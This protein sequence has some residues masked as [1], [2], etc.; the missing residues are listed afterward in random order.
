MKSLG[1]ALL[2]SLMVVSAGCDSEPASISAETQVDTD[3]AGETGIVTLQIQ[4]SGEPRTIEIAEVAAGTT[5]EEVMRSVTQIPVS[6]RGSGITAFVDGI[7]DQSASGIEGWVFRVDGVHAKQGVGS[8][9]L[10]PPTTISWNY[11][12]ANDLV[13][14]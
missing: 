8:T 3:R 13:A 6:I 9:S 14:D 2:C 4:G 10:S 7:G 12:D 11:G 1:L 5:L